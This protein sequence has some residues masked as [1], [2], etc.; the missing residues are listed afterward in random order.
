M[1]GV[2]VMHG[3]TLKPQVCITRYS[4]DLVHPAGLDR[5]SD[6]DEASF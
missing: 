5:F 2:V 3:Q 6:S 4:M 1:S